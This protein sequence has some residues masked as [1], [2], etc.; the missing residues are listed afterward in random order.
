MVEAVMLHVEEA[1]GMAWPG[2]AARKGHG[3]H[4]ARDT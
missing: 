3:V 4:N 2:D 1:V